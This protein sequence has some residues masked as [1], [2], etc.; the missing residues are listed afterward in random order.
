MGPKPTPVAQ[1]LADY[2]A[3]WGVVANDEL[4]GTDKA[5][6]TVDVAGDAWDRLQSGQVWTGKMRLFNS[7]PCPAVFDPT[8]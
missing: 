7:R 8:S 3:A 5:R 2:L 1:I 6:G 4:A